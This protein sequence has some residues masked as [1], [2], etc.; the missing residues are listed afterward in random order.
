M[1]ASPFGG[2]RCLVTGGAGFIG[3][4]LT[5]QLLRQGARVT[6]LDNFTTGTVRNLPRDEGLRIVE[7]DLA[8]ERRLT[9][10]VRGADY[11]F[12]LAAQVGNLKSIEQPGP[13]AATNVLGTVR[14]LEACRGA[15]VR[16]LVYSSSSAIFGEAERVPI[17]ESHPVNPASFYALSKLTGERYARLAAP[18]WGC[19][20]C[21]FGT[22]T[23]S[24]SRW[25]RTS[26]RA[27][28]GSSSI[29]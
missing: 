23:C 22:S 20:P 6:V 16:K 29:D 12:H 19:R 9:E 11:V 27:S 28:S 3:S 24:G 5:A 17:D 18:L 10:L 7:G 26:T 2:A 15:A 4:N 14:L 21:A 8:S 1:S 13:D 25:L